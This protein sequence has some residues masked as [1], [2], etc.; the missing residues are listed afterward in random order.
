MDKEDLISRKRLMSIIKPMTGMFTDEGFWLDYH[1]VLGAI[2]SAPT[3]VQTAGD[4]VE[5]KAVIALLNAPAEGESEF[6]TKNRLLY[7]VTRMPVAIPA[8]RKEEC[9][10]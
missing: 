9:V 7:E 6:V 10:L 5:R 1:A 3:V 2:E 8:E 4:L